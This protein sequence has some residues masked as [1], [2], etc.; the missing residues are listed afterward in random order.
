MLAAVEGDHLAGHRIE[1]EDRHQP[2]GDALGVGGATQRQARPGLFESVW[3]L[4]GWGNGG[5]GTKGIVA[6]VRRQRLGERA[7]RGPQHRFRQ[8]VA[9]IGRRQVQDAFI[10]DVDDVAFGSGRKLR[11]EVA[12]KEY[13]GLGVNDEMG[14]P[15]RFVNVGNAVGPEDRGVV[16][17]QGQRS[18]TACR[19]PRQARPR[20]RPGTGQ[21]RAQG[22]PPRARPPFH[23]RRPRPGRPSRPTRDSGHCDHG[24]AFGR[25]AAGDSRADAIGGAGHQRYLW[26]GIWGV[27]ADVMSRNGGRVCS[28]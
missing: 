11:R 22:S 27:R 26:G 5:A 20:V 13:R 9:Q 12:G 2:F 24:I 16:D 19:Q 10:D 4:A 1:L 23:D 25:E 14:I 8:G 21:I 18:R 17:E 7:G 15:E 3:W 28:A 6:N